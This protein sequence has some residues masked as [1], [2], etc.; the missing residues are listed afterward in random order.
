MTRK[1]TLWIWNKQT[2][3]SGLDSSSITSYLILYDDNEWS[4]MTTTKIK[5]WTRWS[6]YEYEVTQIP[7]LL[8]TSHK[9]FNMSNFFSLHQTLKRRVKFQ[10]WA[11]FLFSR[12][13]FT[14]RMKIIQILMW[15][16]IFC[17]W[18]QDEMKWNILNVQISQILQISQRQDL[19][20]CLVTN[21]INIKYHKYHNNNNRIIF[22]QMAQRSLPAVLL[23][24]LGFVE[25]V[26]IKGKKIVIII[27]FNH[28]HH[29]H[30]V[31]PLWFC[32]SFDG[33]ES[34]FSLSLDF[35]SPPGFLFQSAMN[36][37]CKFTFCRF[38]LRTI[39]LRWSRCTK[40]M[41]FPINSSSLFPQNRFH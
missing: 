17:F 32:W 3:G 33:S 31:H 16:V 36:F 21:V 20:D 37:F 12:S 5:T 7:T 6:P 15:N 9:R 35:F 39:R 24:L 38:F 27:I 4:Y 23:L 10:I 2:G 34:P 26:D 18:K 14:Q 13:L 1:M 22:P 25:A 40:R 41:R 19:P 29:H 8:P 11:V 30:Q 28:H